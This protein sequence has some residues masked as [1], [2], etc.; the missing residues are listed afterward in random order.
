MDI[1]YRSSTPR[2]HGTVQCESWHWLFWARKLML[3]GPCFFLHPAAGW[4]RINWLYGEAGPECLAGYGANTAVLIHSSITMVMAVGVAQLNESANQS[5][6]GRDHS[7]LAWCSWSSKA[8]EY[9]AKF[10]HGHCP[11]AT[12]LRYL[13]SRSR[14]CTPYT[15]WG[16]WW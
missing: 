12:R 10:H 1:P 15:F 6:H 4:V 11:A 2:R 5:L 8:F 3:S 7:A 14:A 16:A 13:F 9:N